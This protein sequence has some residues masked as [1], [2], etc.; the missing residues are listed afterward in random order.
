MS[1]PELASAALSDAAHAAR[2]GRD[3]RHH[4]ARAVAIYLAAGD[5]PSAARLARS[6]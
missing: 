2:A 1:L 4:I 5:V 6:L 3:P